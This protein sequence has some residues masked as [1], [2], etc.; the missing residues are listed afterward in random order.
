MT[1]DMAAGSRKNADDGGGS[2]N[3]NGSSNRNNHGTLPTIK[4]LRAEE[5]WVKNGKEVFP[6]RP[7]S[8]VPSRV[9]T[10]RGQFSQH[11]QLGVLLCLPAVI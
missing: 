1:I 2:S 3:K 5:G 8:I 7:V 4:Q 6:A 11:G 10:S 9:A